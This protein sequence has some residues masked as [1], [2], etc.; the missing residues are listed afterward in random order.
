MGGRKMKRKAY[1]NRQG[2]RRILSF[3]ITL[4]LIT[5]MFPLQPL[6]KAVATDQTP[7][8]SED[9]IYNFLKISE[10][11]MPGKQWSEFKQTGFKLSELNKLEKTTKGNTEEIYSESSIVTEPW[12]FVGTTA[13]DESTPHYQWGDMYDFTDGQGTFLQMK[14]KVKGGYYQAITSHTK[15]YYSPC[16]DVFLAPV[17]DATNATNEKYKLGNVDPSVSYAL[18][19]TN[20]S[21][22]NAGNWTASE[23]NLGNVILNDGEYLLT[24]QFSKS[25]INKYNTRFAVAEFALKKNKIQ[26]DV[27]ASIKLQQ[28][29]RVP[30]SLGDAIPNASYTAVSDN[31]SIAK[32]TVEQ[33]DLV[34]DGV[35]SGKTT[36]R[37][38]ASVNGVQVTEC[39][40]PVTVEEAPRDFYYNFLKIS[41]YYM[42]DRQYSAYWQTGVPLANVDSINKTTKGDATEI[43][44]ESSIKTDPWCFVQSNAKSIT[45]PHYQWGSMLDFSQGAG[46]LLQY[47]VNLT[48]SG[49]FEVFT[50][51]TKNY[52]S[53]I[54][55]VY[56]T[57]ITDKDNALQ[58]KYL[59]GRID[60]SVSYSLCPSNGGGINAGNWSASEF[61][62][63]THN[64]QAG[65][66][67]LTYSF[68]EN[69]TN[70]L[71]TRFMSAGLKLKNTYVDPMTL[72]LSASTLSSVIVGNDA[73]STLSLVDV[74]NN[75]VSFEAK[76]V[77]LE[78]KDPEVAT[79][80][81]S[82]DG[83]TVTVH[84]V[85]R[86]ETS[87]KVTVSLGKNASA[88][89]DIPISIVGDV[90]AK[91]LKAGKL[92]ELAVGSSRTTALQLVNG[93][94]EDVAFE[95]KNVSTVIR[96]ASIAKVTIDPNGGNNLI[97]TGL[98]EGKTTIDVSVSINGSI[99]GTL[100]IP[101]TVL[102]EYA[103]TEQTTL[104][105]DFMK[106]SQYY[107][108]NKAQAYQPQS[109]INLEQTTKGHANEIY[110]TNS[111]QTDP[112]CYIASSV[113]TSDFSFD[114]ANS[115]VYGLKLDAAEKQSGWARL[116]IDVPADGLYQA[117][118]SNS[119]WYMLGIVEFFLAPV[120]ADDPMAA[121]YSLGVI[122]MYRKYDTGGDA[123]NWIVKDRLGAC[124]LS[125][126]EYY[127]TYKVIGTSSPYASYQYFVSGFD[128]E[129]MGN[130]QE[131]TFTMAKTASLKAGTTYETG[132]SLTLSNGVAMNLSAADIQIQSQDNKIATAETMVDPSTKQVNLKVHGVSKGQ[133]D[134]HVSVY[135]NGAK[136]GDRTISVTV[137]EAGYLSSVKLKFDGYDSS[138]ISMQMMPKLI[139]ELYDQ[140]GET[141]PNIQ[142]A[143]Y[144]FESSNPNVATILEN[145]SII[146]ISTGE[147]TLYA[148]VTLNGVTK[149]GE[150][151]IEVS[152]GKTTSTYYTEARVTATRENANKYE[153]AKKSKEAVIAKADKYLEKEEFLW[154]AVT[155][156][157]LPRGITV[158]YRYDPNANHCRYCN[159]DL[160]AEYGEYAWIIDP[161]KEPWKIQC[162]SC[163]RK[164]PSN[165]FNSFYKSGI[166]ANGNWS[167]EK[168]KKDGQEYLKNVLYPEKG[169]GWGV[170]D[171]YGYKTGNT[172]QSGSNQIEE[173]HTYIAYYNHWGL[174]HSF[175]IIQDALSNL[176]AAYVYTGDKRYGRVGAI[177]IDRVADVYP[178]MNLEP[179]FPRFFNSDSSQPSGKA[180]GSIWECSP[181]KSM[182]R[183]YDAFYPMMDDPQVISFLSDKAKTY[184]MKNG[185]NTA[186]E[187][188][189]NCED[190]ILR[191]IYRAAKRAD[192]WGNFGMHQSSVATAAV[193]L[194][195]MPETKEMID[196]VMQSGGRASS[197]VVTGGNVLEQILATVDRD[198]MGTE[199]SPQYN[200]LW[201][202]NL[203]ILADTMAG[204]KGYPSADL[205]NN[206]KF[207]K[208]FTAPIAL[209]L[210]RQGTAQIGDSGRVASKSFTS[211]IPLL[212]RAFQLT[213]KPE[214]AQIIYLLNGNKVDGL[215]GDIYSKDP[216]SI[217]KEILD[218]IH[219]YGEYDMD[220]SEQIAGYGFSILRGGSYHPAENHNDSNTQRDFWIY[221]GSGIGHRHPD[222]LNLGLEAFGVNMAP[223][224]GYP[225]ACDGSDCY[226]FWS[227]ATLNHN[228]VMVN[229]RNQVELGSGNGKPLHFDDS[230]RVK[231]MDVDMP[232]CYSDV[233]NYRRTVV[234]VEASDEVSYGID[235][236]RI[237]GGNDHLYSFHSQS[238]EITEVEGV[239]LVP[240]A[241]DKG[242]FIGSYAGPNVPYGTANSTNGYAWFKNVEKAE[243]PGTGKFAADF[244]VKDFRNTIQNADDLHLRMTMVNDFNLSE[245]SVTEGIPAQVDDNPK[246]LKFV[247]AR[248][249]GNNL[250]SLFTTVYEPYRG[251]R[252]IK[253]ID[254]V[255]VTK[256]DGTP[257]DNTVKAVKITLTN[258]RVDYIVYA[259]DNSVEYTIDGLFNFKGFVG[260][261]T[262][263]DG[264]AV[265]SYL[266][267]G[268]RI[269]DMVG[270]TAYTG[271]VVDF[272]KDLA[273]ENSI[274]VQMDQSIDVSTLAGKH[275]YIKND[276]SENAVYA[277]LSAQKKENGQVMLN[278]GNVT[279]IRGS[280]NSSDLKQG[281]VYNIAAGQKFRIPLATVSDPSPV[282]KPIE[283]Q[284]AEV[285]SELKFRVQAESKT[286]AQLTYSANSLPRGAQ[287]DAN[288][289]TFKWIPDCGQ[290]GKQHVSIDVTDGVLTST[291]HVEVMVYSSSHKGDSNFNK[292][293]INIPS[294]NDPVKPPV[295]EKTE[296]AEST[297][298]LPGTNNNQKEIHIETK[299]AS[300]ILPASGFNEK[301]N[302]KIVVK[303]D[304]NNFDISLT[305]NGKD[306]ELR[307]PVKVSIPYTKS[308]N[309]K[310]ENCIIVKDE[311]GNIIPRGLYNNGKIQFY[312][313]KLGK[314]SITY[315][316]KVFTDLDNHTWAKDAV[317]R[318]ASRDIIKGITV[319]TY[320]PSAN[321]TRADFITLVVRAFGFT[322]E[323]ND[324]FTDVDVNKHYAQNIGIAKTLG[325][326]T[327][328]GDNK[329]NPMAEITRQDMMVIVSRA[330]EVAKY[331]IPVIE[332]HSFMDTNDVAGYAKDAVKKLADSGIITGMNGKIN[333]K[334]KST[335]AEIAVILDRIIFQTN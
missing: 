78:V 205:Y 40:I 286:G 226:R 215:H 289:Q 277:I 71:S 62:L 72:T 197:H 306:F 219:T 254:S 50:Y 327:G 233:D 52:Y 39:Q 34:I 159:A 284:T 153:W 232:Q 137:S 35:A 334:G 157:E 191:E 221:Y 178:D 323:G 107:V 47:K 262:V 261:H 128:L 144:V 75:P 179:Y 188:R 22:V 127:L 250:D 51:N 192:I 259:A 304:K 125:K 85:Q 324:N 27:P 134:I 182:A 158:G 61:P 310:D 100:A 214:F 218:I 21:G 303:K 264:K 98:A 146:P 270:E 293:D 143:S 96:D 102:K 184:Q 7:S 246:M 161:L 80:S 305:V 68:A 217:Q 194:D 301:G 25:G 271:S 44:A 1:L 206:P 199:S 211:N 189:Q 18:C 110:P 307:E 213:G 322:A 209:T 279:L 296:S 94:D 103:K 119:H 111:K 36:V 86:G 236:F 138:R 167:Y 251:S 241:D 300:L 24:Y 200:A 9:L 41:E 11:Y 298:E 90:N 89:V 48:Q 131:L 234:M 273:F 155:T 70:K 316:E 114:P 15:N 120:N 168:A 92:Q 222:G 165:D 292:P 243:N 319:N 202:S 154:N 65:E 169:E 45:S 313:D 204:Y 151:S 104:H 268:M 244:K 59:L 37:V 256:A 237:K 225:E 180:I 66:Y 105:Y 175:G 282:F 320:S 122:D 58:E 312:T 294:N 228:T 13:K 2:M 30:I 274:T 308:D 255:P 288:T 186:A 201:L 278:L 276:G 302:G 121:K 126:G 53:P 54:V 315:N 283:K 329:Y 174:W 19:P 318:L 177:L 252:Y 272:T 129:P 28:Q 55:D 109:V 29:V 172:I 69:G 31:V 16:V 5:G 311:A 317:I 176:Q 290:M 91:I 4:C 142:G 76:N 263:K 309:M 74:S 163:R 326:V 247:F 183:A 331:A 223:D 314:I 43:H 38:T 135:M 166:D 140:D 198:G 224:L 93:N 79:A 162:P 208:M 81:V 207:I 3:M 275:I 235:F 203:S 330:L 108:D 295:D 95:M 187:I 106:L 212:I 333:P 60:P 291:L 101:V 147:T 269:G 42:P 116:K 141:I 149:R 10:Y 113:K 299:L 332:E 190:G 12:C 195:S 56:L 239:K 132:M 196:W 145:G 160:L 328:Q 136:V 112:W 257:A 227:R 152:D 77:T 164:F 156:Q 64:L 230:G 238:D 46:T 185:K 171:G 14:L 23:F 87:L 325:I 83:K 26:A 57:P 63:G 240:Q 321:I 260:V 297:F 210:A 216:E 229:N 170:D 258:D 88:S 115:Y 148:D 231:V 245:V 265:Y 267:D 266:N 123:A 133:T 150:Y 173:C 8:N 6:N 33:N 287:F 99:A 20:K 130:S 220:K 139:C 285:G 248:R 118:S 82:N 97:V 32:A 242:Q 253:S 117:V 73:Q 124:M 281:F 17:S 181:T 335:R 249:T 193:V 49:E 280:K 84:G 67:L